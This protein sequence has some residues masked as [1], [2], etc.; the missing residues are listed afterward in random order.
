MSDE[1]FG[2]AT[3]ILLAVMFCALCFFIGFLDPIDRWVEKWRKRR[4]KPA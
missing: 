3:I 1:T 2:L 4:A